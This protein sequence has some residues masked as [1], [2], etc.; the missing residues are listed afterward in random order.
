MHKPPDN[1]GNKPPLIL[2]PVQTHPCRDEVYALSVYEP[3]AQFTSTAQVLTQ[4]RQLLDSHHLAS[5]HG[6]LDWA[7]LRQLPIATRG[8]FHMHCVPTGLLHNACLACDG[9]VDGVLSTSHFFVL[10]LL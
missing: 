2:R 4:D 8:T 10:Q 6:R 9:C 3:A 5:E 1:Q 7:A